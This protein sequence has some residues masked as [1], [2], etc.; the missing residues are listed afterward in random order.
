MLKK[1]LI[2]SAVLAASSTIAFAG[3]P[4]VGVGLGVND[5]Q[6]KISDSNSSVN[7]FGARGAL[8]NVFAGYGALV[9]QNIYLG[10]EVFFNGTSTQA[11]VTED[12]GDYAKLT[13]R[14]SYGVSFIPGVML[15]DHTLAYLRAG[16]VR[17]QFRAQAQDETLGYGAQTK[18]VTGGQLGLGMQTSLAQNVDLRGE[19][20]YTGYRSYTLKT[21]NT[22]FSPSTD[23]FNLAL[24]YKF[25]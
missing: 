5:S 20:V 7:K 13:T 1:L 18:N 24:L 19:Y 14:S 25:D 9:S 3:T 2:A 22:K 21:T 15:T 23:Q 10:G 16:V 11:K 17:G 4:Y 8:L 12:N 6:T